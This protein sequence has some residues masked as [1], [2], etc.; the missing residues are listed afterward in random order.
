M[1]YILTLTTCILITVW[2]INKVLFSDFNNISAQKKNITVLVSVFNTLLSF[3]FASKTGANLIYIMSL[4][5]FC[6][7][8]ISMFS[9][10]NSQQEQIDK[11]IKSEK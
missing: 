4:L 3:I 6:A 11:A 2:L 10:I 1:I 8:I 5:S 7:F 9:I